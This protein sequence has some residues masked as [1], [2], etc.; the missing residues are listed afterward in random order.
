MLKRPHYIALGVV[1]L[2]TFALIKLPTR[3]AGNLKLAIG[4]VFL[5][6]FG[7]A[8]SLGDLAENSSY[9]LLSRR[10]LIRQLQWQ[11]KTNQLSQLYFRQAE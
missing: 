7:M 3:A 9:S 1:I 4:G 11:H 5:P 2:F 8:G 6:L 10:E